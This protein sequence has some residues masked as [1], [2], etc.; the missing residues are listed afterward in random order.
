MVAA[1]AN[2]EEIDLDGDDDDEAT[3]SQDG[4]RDDPDGMHELMDH[5]PAGGLGTDLASDSGHG[6]TRLEDDPMFQP[7]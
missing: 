5:S 6:G 2:P 7:L 4:P 1:L 3:A